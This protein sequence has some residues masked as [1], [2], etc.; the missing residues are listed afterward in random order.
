M[1]RSMRRLAALPP[2]TVVY[3]GHDYGPTR[4]STIADENLHNPC[5]QP[6]TLEAWRGS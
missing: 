5:L 6:K 4:T 1:F 2:E 3:P